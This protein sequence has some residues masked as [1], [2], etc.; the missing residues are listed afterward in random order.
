MQFIRSL[1][2]NIFLYLGII[3]VFILAIPSLML[4]SKFALIFGKILANY[5]ILILRVFLNTKV[6]F[7]GLENLKKT[8]KFFVASAH[9]SMFE[10]F[11]LQKPLHFPIFILKKE[12][13]KIPLFGWYLKKIGSIGI[14]RETT[15]KDNLNFFDK[16]KKAMEKNKRPILIFPQGTRVKFGEK[17]PFKKGVGRIYESLKLPCV[18]VALNSGKIWP[19]NSFMKYKGNIH[20]SFLNPIMPGKDKSE[21]LK[22]I[23]DKIYLEIEK[24]N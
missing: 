9:Q 10:T 23:E 18:P 19:K 14:I 3:L 12:L 22:E 13:F 1:I 24:L 7:H 4:P 21:F 5:I 6:V 8:E 16:I 20:I 2:F 15:T 11:V 17:I